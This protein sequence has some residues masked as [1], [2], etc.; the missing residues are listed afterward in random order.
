MRLSRGRNTLDP[1]PSVPE[2]TA[3]TVQDSENPTCDL[4]ET[5]YRHERAEQDYAGVLPQGVP[6][7]LGV[8]IVL[9]KLRTRRRRWQYWF[10][11]ICKGIESPIL[12]PSHGLLWRVVGVWC[13]EGHG[14]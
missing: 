2:Q 3:R 8:S 11:P 9:L 14:T 6:F 12:L 10:V 4:H 13:D 7:L 5:R 1:A